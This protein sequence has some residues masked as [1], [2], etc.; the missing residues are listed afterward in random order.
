MP[1]ESPGLWL[2]HAPAGKGPFPPEAS[3]WPDTPSLW[4]EVE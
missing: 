1:V 2:A 4:A 3:P